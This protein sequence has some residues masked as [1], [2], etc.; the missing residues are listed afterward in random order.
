MLKRRFFWTITLALL[1]LVGVI[2]FSSAIV[3]LRPHKKQ[4][5]RERTLMVLRLAQDIERRMEIPRRVQIIAEN[6]DFE[7][8]VIEET[9]KHIKKA[10]TYKRANRE[11]FYFF[12]KKH[13]AISTKLTF[14]DESSKWLIVEYQAD[15]E[16]PLQGLSLLL[17]VFGI[18]SFIGAYLLT[19]WIF[20]P[21]ENAMNAMTKIASGDLQHRVDSNLEPV[22]SV[23]NQMAERVESTIDGQR[24]LIAAISHELRTPITRLRLRA[25]IQNA[26][27]MIQDIDELE[28]LVSVLLTS[29]K[30]QN[31]VWAIQYTQ[32]N[33]K[34]IFY[35]ILAKVDIEERF[36]HID[37]HSNTIVA[38]LILFKRVLENIVSNFTKYCPNG[39]NLYFSTRDLDNHFMELYFSDDGAGI[40]PS[41]EAHIF[42]PFFREEESRNKKLG[43][44]GLGLMLVQQIIDSHNGEIS[45]KNRET[46]KHG[47]FDIQIK[48]PISNFLKK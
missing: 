4:L 15:L 2:W 28:D 39:S 43:G 25:E 6:M 30:L 24:K 47:G 8:H 16:S 32:I 31:S 42:E 41:N 13:P 3:I 5:M 44:L 40:S 20:V 11:F 27:D 36:V 23:F 26:P 38:D 21:L 7:I 17:I 14:K 12:Y 33:I 37:I 35:E 46:S 29:S 10:K 18:L 45:I 48:L 22:S 1:T 9:P 19:A 34:D